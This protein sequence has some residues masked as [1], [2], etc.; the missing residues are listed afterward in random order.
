LLTQAILELESGLWSV[1]DSSTRPGCK[2]AAAS[3]CSVLGEEVL[4]IPYRLQI[5]GHWQIAIRFSTWGYNAEY[6]SPMSSEAL[7]PPGAAGQGSTLDLA[8][9]HRISLDSDIE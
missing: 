9:D 6:P 5:P 3:A 8:V 4:K 1:L 2:A 7:S